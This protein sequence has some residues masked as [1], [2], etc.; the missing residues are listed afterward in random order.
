MIFF[1]LTGE[2]L[3]IP[4]PPMLMGNLLF[5]HGPPLLV[6]TG[7]GPLDPEPWPLGGV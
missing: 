5:E 3:N 6:T 7:G 4:L 2:T 1:F